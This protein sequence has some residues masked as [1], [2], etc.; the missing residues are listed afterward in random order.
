MLENSTPSSSEYLGFV[1]NWGSVISGWCYK[2]ATPHTPILLAVFVDGQ[3]IGVVGCDSPRP[4]VSKS[5][6]ATA[7]CGFYVDIGSTVTDEDF[8]AVELV[9]FYSGRVIFTSVEKIQCYSP[10]IKT[11]FGFVG[12]RSIISIKGDLEELKMAIKNSA[13]V[14]FVSSF[15]Y[16]DKENFS[17]DRLVRA[18][19]NC[20]F[21][22]VVID[23]S[24]QM[25]DIPSKVDLHIHRRNIGWDFASW[26][27]A[28]D[29]LSWDFADCSQVILTN[30]SCLGPIGDLQM[31]FDSG[32]ALDV[33]AFSITD[34]WQGGY[35][36]QS[37]FLSFGSKVNKSG[38]LSRFFASYEFPIQK[39]KIIANGEISLSQKLMREGFAIGAL[40]PYSDLREKYLDD[41][42]VS[43][44][45]I[46]NSK[47]NSRIRELVPS[48]IPSEAQ[49]LLRIYD[50][51][52]SGKLVNPSHTF[53][54][55]LVSANCQLLKRDLIA[56]NPAEVPGLQT[57]FELLNEKSTPEEMEYSKVE[58]GFK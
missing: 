34:S 41:F 11:D 27:T 58:L 43:F 51:L 46:I 31:T 45:R 13:R 36:L 17:V 40:F 29:L 2:I 18:L 22:V 8:H 10:S 9:E 28:L 57:L 23:T 30:D 32:A 16:P 35:H 52:N 25:T 4:D 42:P 5:G 21:S 50:D 49:L 6:L 39:D 47:T 33:D 44:E 38:F 19:K 55:L 7:N 56:N 12:L 53:W 20:G 1:E 15:T 26:F 24:K 37:Y 3:Q 48:Y 54:K 14:A